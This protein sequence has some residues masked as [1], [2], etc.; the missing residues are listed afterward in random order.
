MKR[1]KYYYRKKIEQ[2]IKNSTQRR[3]LVS[4]KNNSLLNY[5]LRQYITN[6]LN[7]KYKSNNFNRLK[8]FCLVTGKTRSVMSS[9]KVNKMVVLEDISE[10]MFSGFYKN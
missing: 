8:I 3:V 7:C 5:H 1:H 6:K 4:L 10:G 2:F 9:F